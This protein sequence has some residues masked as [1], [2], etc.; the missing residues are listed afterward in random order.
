LI[1]Q[2]VRSMAQV[3]QQVSQHTTTAGAQN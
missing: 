2:R 1:E 3:E